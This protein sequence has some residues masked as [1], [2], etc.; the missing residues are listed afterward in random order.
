MHP[1]IRTHP[2]PPLLFFGLSSTH[3]FLRLSLVALPK[4]SL[5]RLE[6]VGVACIR[7]AYGWIHNIWTFSVIV[8]IKL[9]DVTSEILREWVRLEFL[10]KWS[11][12]LN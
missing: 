11:G 12:Y 7:A 2:H 1:P 8:P 10:L 3:N 6:S 9:M 5:G 4:S